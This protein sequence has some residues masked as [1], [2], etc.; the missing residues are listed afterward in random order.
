PA[1]TRK[2]IAGWTI[3]KQFAFLR[4]LAAYGSV[5]AAARSVGMSEA[6]AWRLRARPGADS[7]CRAWDTALQA[8]GAHLLG[9]ALDRALN[10]STR[11]YWKNGELVGEQ[12]APSDKLLMWA[13]DRLRPR[14]ATRLPNGEAVFQACAG[15]TDM[16]RAESEDDHLPDHLAQPAT[17]HVH[18]HTRGCTR[19]HMRTPAPLNPPDLPDL[20]TP[21]SP[22]SH[23]LTGHHLTGQSDH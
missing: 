9:V 17:P 7:F 16:S 19:E 15:L 18:T 3:E 12:V 6:S 1:P 11:Q 4:H 21:R 23:H 20:S 22:P 5:A 14:N 13:V 2:H 10:G 8:A